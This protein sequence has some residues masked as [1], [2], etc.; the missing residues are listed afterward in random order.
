MDV[1]SL[2]PGTLIGNYKILKAQ[3]QGGFG[4]TYIA[5]D[6][7]LER[8]VVL[9]ECF[10]ATIC[11]RTD[12]GGLVP[13]QEHLADMYVAAMADMRREA[14]MLAK[15]SHPGIV[16]VYDVFE[17]QGSLFYVMPWLN[18]GS[19]RERM[20]EA[21][22][23]EKSIEPQLAQEWLL[24]VLDALVYL[25]QQGVIHRDLKPDNIVFN[26]EDKP[27][28]ID[29]GSARKYV[30]HSVSQGEFSW[31]YAAPE[32]ITGKGELGPWTD[33]YSLAT[34]W[35]EVLSGCD[36]EDTVRRLQKDELVP[37]RK[38]KGA[39]KW[40]R[41]MVDSIMRNMS[42]EPVDRCE[43]AEQWRDWLSKSAQPRGLKAKQRWFSLPRWAWY[44]LFGV[45]V[46]FGR[47]AAQLYVEA[48]KSRPMATDTMLVK[49]KDGMLMVEKVPS[50]PDLKPVMF[51]PKGE[52]NP[53]GEQAGTA[54][55]PQATEPGCPAFMEKLYA[56]FCAHHAEAIQ[57]FRE[58]KDELLRQRSAN[59]QE[60][61]R[62]VAALKAELLPQIRKTPRP[63]GAIGKL[64]NP[65]L[66]LKFEVDAQVNELCQEF[67][68]K[69]QPL[70]STLWDELSPIQ[71]ILNDPAAH[72]PHGS[73]DELVRLP[74]LAERLKEEIIGDVRMD[75]LLL[76]VPW[77]D[78]NHITDDWFKQ[79]GAD[80]PEQE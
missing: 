25:H 80:A 29:F 76:K 5:W 67:R 47:F 58:R 1:V 71:E 17:S 28:L 54:D 55:P 72:Y 52:E 15:L 11:R 13:Q 51:I 30:E 37:L 78:Y 56:D 59:V 45:A 68:D 3:G 79:G 2:P 26:A 38:L 43:T 77:R 50:S 48:H 64:D 19:L 23:A 63:A 66:R 73:T 8:N 39:R 53:S 75:A 44:L 62:R 46:A 12:T 10:P 32:H 6:K 60:F 14:M 57:V 40:P 42:L 65:W 31:R 70:L 27:V 4:I 9:K 34:T 41:A 61:E 22:E 74:M 21:Q 36:A 35:Y 69:D 49:M 7:G 16:P 20:D 18:G 24:D 33:M